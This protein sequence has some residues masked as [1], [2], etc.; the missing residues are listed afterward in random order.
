MSPGKWV[1]LA[2]RLIDTPFGTFLTHFLCHITHRG[3]NKTTIRAATCKRLL[4]LHCRIRTELN[5]SYHIKSFFSAF[6]YIITHWELYQTRLIHQEL[7]SRSAWLCRVLPV[8]R[9]KVT[10]TASPVSQPHQSLWRFPRLSGLLP[11]LIIQSHNNK[12]TCAAI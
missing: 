1:D 12:Q 8:T 6:H 3:R 7:A 9:D 2:D 4:L 11:A 10:L 5:Q